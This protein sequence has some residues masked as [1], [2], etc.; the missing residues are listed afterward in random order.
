MKRNPYFDNIKIVMLF[1]VVLGH[2]IE[3]LLGKSI[4]LDMIYKTIYSFH[5]PV[6]VFVSGLLSS[7]KNGNELKLIKTLLIPFLI[8]TILYEVPEYLRYGTLGFYSNLLIP[9]WFLWYLISLFCWRIMAP[10]FTKFKISV[11]LAFILVMVA[12]YFDSINYAFGLSRTIYYF[13][14]FLLGFQFSQENYTQSKL[15]NIPNIYCYIIL[16]INVIIFF[17]F[18]QIKVFWMYGSLPYQN[19]ETTM[20]T[21]ILIRFGML[22]LSLLSVI[23]IT[24]LITTKETFYTERGKNSLYIYLWHGYLIKLLLMLQVTSIIYKKFPVYITIPAL[25]MLS[26]L[27]VYI[28]SFSFVERFTMQFII[29][30][31]NKLLLKENT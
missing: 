28:L 21:A 23:A 17:S 15:F 8:F 31:V 25:A 16:I 30:P 29:N 20:L 19:M 3:T 7:K 1:F 24:N 4:T 18:R 5:M 11:L 22:L 12:G 26:I 2:L 27:I 10:F 13:P 9:Y 14:F 6:F